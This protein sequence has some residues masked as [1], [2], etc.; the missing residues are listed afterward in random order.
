MN[1][2]ETAL[3]LIELATDGPELWR[4]TSAQ[5]GRSMEMLAPLAEIDGKAFRL[6]VESWCKDGPAKQAPNGVSEHCFAG[7]VTG[8]EGLTL[9]IVFRV[10]ESSPVIRF[11]YILESTQPRRMTKSTGR[12]R[13]EYVSASLSGL[14]RATEVRFGEFNELSH[15][16]CLSERQVGQGDFEAGLSLIGPM[17]VAGDGD[18]TVLLAYEHGSQV[19]DAFLSFRLSPDRRICLEAVKGNYYDGRALGPETPFESIWLQVAGVDGDHQKLAREYRRFIL[20]NQCPNRETRKP[21][22]FYNTWNCQERDRWSGSGKYL[23]TINEERMLAEIDVAAR[24][25][26]EVF[27]LD[28]GWYVKTGDWRINTDRFSEKLGVIKKRL[29]AHGMKLGLWFDPTAAAVSSEMAA[30]HPDCVQVRNG[31]E[32]PLRKIWE[33]ESSHT[34][35]LVSRYADAFADELIRLAKEVGVTYFKLDAITQRGCDGAGHFHG[36][37]GNSQAERDDCY[38]FEVGRSVQ[39]IA[40]KLAENCP[41]AIVDFDVTEGWRYFGLGFLAV[42]KYFLVN[43]GPYYFS[44]DVPTPPPGNNNMFF[45]PGPARTWICRMPLSLDKWVPSVLFL[46]HYLPDDPTGSQIV[47]LAS[48]ILGQNGIWGDLTKVSDEGVERIGNIIRLYRQVRD[49]ITEAYPAR[50]GAVGGSPEIHEK[51]SPGGRGAICVF[52]NAKGTYQYVSRNKVVGTFWATEGAS[53]ELDSAGRAKLELAFTEPGA[54]IALFGV[55]LRE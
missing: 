14:D 24:M 4:F 27:V 51:I 18:W 45:H 25:G 15:S 28:T 41:E 37:E 8:L 9:R 21:Y 11:R 43:N 23:G 47:N 46:T 44:Y 29:D 19:P 16:Y 40:A 32:A 26:I 36:S 33:T 52:A 12:D 42:G 20:E 6:S 10:A 49:D 22:I 34:M 30:C 3:Y 13:M 5:S 7:L 1:S 53:V 2:I 55:D 35:C 17:L 39:R 31:A 50:S 38:A 54:H 48:M